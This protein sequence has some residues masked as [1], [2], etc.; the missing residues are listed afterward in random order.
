MRASK[1]LHSS[2]FA[3]VIAVGS[4]SARGDV[5]YTYNLDSTGSFGSGPYGTVL[6]HQ[7]GTSVDFTVTL[8]SNLQFVDTG[9]PH[10]ALSFNATGVSPAD[11]TN[12][13]FNGVSAATLGFTVSV[14]DTSPPITNGNSPYGST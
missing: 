4:V 13:E 8:A 10:S 2:L 14:A 6:L 9:G 3:L 12:V 1:F 7:D 5:L 11:V